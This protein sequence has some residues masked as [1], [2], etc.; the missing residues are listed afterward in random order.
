MDERADVGAHYWLESFGSPLH[1]KSKLHVM[2]SFIVQ[3]YLQV[4]DSDQFWGTTVFTSRTCSRFLIYCVHGQQCTRIDTSVCAFW[5]LVVG[6][7][8]VREVVSDGFQILTSQG[9]QCPCS[10]RFMLGQVTESI[11]HKWHKCFDEELCYRH[12]EQLP[13]CDACLGFVCVVYKALCFFCR[14]P[15]SIQSTVATKYVHPS[16][17]FSSNPFN[18]M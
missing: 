1:S 5:W 10:A 14:C 2:I 7:R 15:T 13:L 16:D 11:V 18:L 9:A 3:G 4:C 8:R 12:T 17:Q 6:T